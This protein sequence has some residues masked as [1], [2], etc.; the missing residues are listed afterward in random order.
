MTVTAY[1]CCFYNFP[2][3]SYVS[4][5]F[6]QESAHRQFSFSGWQRQSS[7]LMTS[8]RLRLH[9][10]T[11]RDFTSLLSILCVYFIFLYSVSIS[12]LRLGRRCCLGTT[13]R[14]FIFL[15]FYREKI[16]IGLFEESCFSDFFAI[17]FISIRFSFS[18][19]EQSIE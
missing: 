6:L 3:P 19:V 14:V 15:F 9:G 1:L 5:S 8:T 4:R 16:C 18:F 12:S 11:L 2:L 10:S 13:I 17:S 7:F